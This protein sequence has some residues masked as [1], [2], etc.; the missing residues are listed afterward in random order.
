MAFQKYSLNIPKE[1]NGT[2]LDEALLQLLPEALKQPVSKSFIR[3][4]IMAGAVSIDQVRVR[5]ASKNLRA[6]TSI[7]V[8]VD[9]AAVEEKAKTQAQDI[10]LKAESILFEDEDIIVVNKPAGLPSQVT[11][12]QNRNHLVA[13]I[14]LL[15]QSREGASKEKPYLGLHHRLDRDTSGVI[16]L[17]K[18]KRANGGMAKQFESRLIQKTYWALCEKIPTGQTLWADKIWSVKDHLKKMQG[19]GK[20][21][22]MQTTRSGGDF[23][24]TDFKVLECGSNWAWVE[25]MPRTGRMHQIRV[26]LANAGWPIVGDFLYGRK[27]DGVRVLLHAAGLTFE[28]PVHKTPLEIVS[29]IPDDAPE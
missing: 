15:L 22:K 4:V 29:P 28:H 17:T 11:L 16:V 19:A 1:L 5:L 18:S 14:T 8:W 6:G 9:Q 25:A 12:D 21:S 20:Q 3:K 13:A 2:R 23:A 7:D 24:H 10:E 27:Q 26:H